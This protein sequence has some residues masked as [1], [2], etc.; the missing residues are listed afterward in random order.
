MKDIPPTNHIRSFTELEDFMD[1]LTS[2]NATIN[3]H[4][5]IVCFSLLFSIHPH[6]VFQDNMPATAIEEPLP[7]TNVAKVAA[8]KTLPEIERKS[9]S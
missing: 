2:S 7:D 4:P 1:N 3:S 5:I 6:F 9:I 8:E